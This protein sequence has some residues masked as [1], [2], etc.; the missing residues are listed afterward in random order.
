VDGGR[1]PVIQV[2]YEIFTPE[3]VK[4]NVTIFIPEKEQNAEKCTYLKVSPFTYF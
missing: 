4:P 2:K 1:L 3:I